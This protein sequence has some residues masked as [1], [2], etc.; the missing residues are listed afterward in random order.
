SFEHEL[1]STTD[2]EGQI[3]V[4]VKL[5]GARVQLALQDVIYLPTNVRPPL[6]VHEEGHRVINERIFDE[7]AERIAREVAEP[8]LVKTWIA[9]GVDR[10]S[11][12]NVA[13]ESAISELR[14]GYRERIVQRVAQVSDKFDELTKHGSN[15]L[16]VVEAIE[17]AFEQ[18]ASK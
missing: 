16:N 14:I 10:E 4:N 3:E 9:R 18:C 12:V 7:E 6:R 2:R 13:L 1:I 15:D 17:R 5:I 11:A 8:M